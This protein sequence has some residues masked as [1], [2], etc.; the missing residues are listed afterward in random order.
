LLSVRKAN[1]LDKR[2]YFQWVN[3]EVVRRHAFHTD[4]IAWKT[5]E[6]WF[7]RKI[8]DENCYLYIAETGKQPVGQIRFDL[9]DDKDEATIDYSIA[10][11]CRGKGMG[12]TM[13]RLAM[14]QLSRDCSSIVA[15]RGEVKPDNFASQKIF[16]GLG[17]EE[18]YEEQNRTEQNSDRLSITVITDPKSWIV[19]YVERL[20]SDIQACLGSGYQNSS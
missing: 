4:L 19:P 2:R 20:E 18:S 8:T 9:D 6:K 7:E 1:K 16:R 5:H 12:K 13:L 11:E 3:D 10:A 15:L 14:E 17:F